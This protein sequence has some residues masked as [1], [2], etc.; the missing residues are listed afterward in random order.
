MHKINDDLTDF[1]KFIPLLA[2]ILYVIFLNRAL[3]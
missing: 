3:H 1:T 2:S